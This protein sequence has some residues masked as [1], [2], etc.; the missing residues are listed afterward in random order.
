MK[1]TKKSVAGRPLLRKYRPLDESEPCTTA[2]RYRRATR[3]MEI[4]Y[5]NGIMISFPVLAIQD[6][7]SLYTRP[8]ESDLRHVSANG[9]SVIFDR[10]G[11]GQ[12]A[13]AAF[14]G[15]FGTL[16]WMETLPRMR[17]MRSPALSK[18]AGRKKALQ[19]LLSTRREDRQV[20]SPWLRGLL[21]VLS[22]RRTERRTAIKRVWREML[23]HGRLP[24]D[25]WPKAEAEACS[26]SGWWMERGWWIQAVTSRP[27]R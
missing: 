3:R 9:W 17:V 12:L 20:S 8:T 13:E 1:R 7:I 16:G 5:E 26:G 11:C 14:R 15:N 27:R 10:L 22:R 21:P 19:V 23:R 2:A 18:R 4:E 6:L 24:L 25:E